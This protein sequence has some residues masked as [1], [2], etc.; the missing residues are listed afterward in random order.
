MAKV[1]EFYISTVRTA[2]EKDRYAVR[3]KTDIGPGEWRRVASCNSHFQALRIMKALTEQAKRS[4]LFGVKARTLSHAWDGATKSM[5]AE[6]EERKKQQ[7]RNEI[8]EEFMAG[9]PL[10]YLDPLS[11]TVSAPAS[12]TIITKQGGDGQLTIT[13]E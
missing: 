12:A 9:T 5:L 4:P 3:E 11:V 10:K 2:W 6:L 7:K 1:G 13:I 8:A